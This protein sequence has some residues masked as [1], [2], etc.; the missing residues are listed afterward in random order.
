M[1]RSA[2]N[3]NER[4]SSEK[5]EYALYNNGDFNL[6]IQPSIDKSNGTNSNFKKLPLHSWMLKQNFID[7][8]RE[9]YPGKKEFT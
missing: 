5:I 9:L 3:Y 4:N 8:F 6:I 7:N 2:K 1:K